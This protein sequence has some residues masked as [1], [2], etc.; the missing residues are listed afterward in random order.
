MKTLV[1]V[2]AL[3][4][5]FLAAGCSQSSHPL[6]TGKVVSGTVW[7]LPVGS[8]QSANKGSQL[9]KDT[10]VDVFDRII[11]VHYNDGNHVVSLENVTGLVLK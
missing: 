5:I 1:N 6:V 3:A 11:V 9:L 7:D 8:A 10:R 2:S 4:C